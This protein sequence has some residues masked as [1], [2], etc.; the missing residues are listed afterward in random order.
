MIKTPDKVFNDSKKYLDIY[1]YSLPF[2][3]IYNIST[4]IFAALGDSKTPFYFLAVS[5]VLNVF[6]DILFVGPL[7]Q[8]VPGTAIATLI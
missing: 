6:M 8:G 2:V 5:S 1:I 4:G 7:N 3:F